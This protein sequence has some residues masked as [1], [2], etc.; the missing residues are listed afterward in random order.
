MKAYWGSGDIDPSILDLATRW[1]WVVSFT[2]RRLYLQGKGPVTHWIGG[3]VDDGEEKN[4]QPQPGLE[5]PI[6]H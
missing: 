2:S 1:R 4:S 3:W 6:I 5:L